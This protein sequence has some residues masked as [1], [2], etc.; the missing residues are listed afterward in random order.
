MPEQKDLEL[1]GEVLREFIGENGAFYR[2]HGFVGVPVGPE[3]T[4]ADW[5]VMN[6][7]LQT[8]PVPTGIPP[9]ETPWD[10]DARQ[11]RVS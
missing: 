9:W 1:Y 3:F 2:R 11:F 10:G 7:A 6:A 5:E 8:L 4:L